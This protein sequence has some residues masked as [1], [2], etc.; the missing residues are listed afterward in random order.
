[1]KHSAKEMIIDWLR[2]V[3]VTPSSEVAA[4]REKG[5]RKIIGSNDQKT[6]LNIVRLAFGLDYK[7]EDADF[8]AHFKKADESFP[9]AGNANLLKV[10]ANICICFKLEGGDSE[11]NHWLS[12]AIRNATFVNPLAPIQHIP[13]LDYSLENLENLAPESRIINIDE[14]RENIA[15]L[16]T[17]ESQEDGKVVL[18]KQFV[19]KLL[20][21]NVKLLEEVNIIWWLFTGYSKFANKNFTEINKTSLPLIAGKELYDL[22]HIERILESAPAFFTK[23]LGEGSD[24]ESNVFDAI[25]SLSEEHRKLIIG[26]NENAISEFTPILKAMNLSL[27]FPSG[28]DWSNAFKKQV[29]GSDIKRPKFAIDIALQLYHEL[30]FIWL[31]EK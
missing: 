21:L 15:E 3:E 26:G 17:D 31:S 20:A 14:L 28:D 9:L 6:W 4:N 1:M 13:I 12:L 10:L 22:M 8:V 5:I 11:F 18:D 29:A 24:R 16:E 19:S 2:T 23:V 27:G 25:N 7:L 30:V